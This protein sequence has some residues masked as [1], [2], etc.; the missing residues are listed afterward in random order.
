[1]RRA[2]GLILLISAA[3]WANQAAAQSLDELFRQNTQPPGLFLSDPV[4]QPD[5]PPTAEDNAYENRVLG[6][7]R[8]AQNAQGSL[9]GRWEVRGANGA[10]IYVLQFVDPG[11]GVARIEGVWRDP[12]RSGFDSTGYIESITAEDGDMVVMFREAGQS[13]ATQVRFRSVGDS[14]WSGQ[15][16]KPNGATVAVTMVRGP[17]VENRALGGG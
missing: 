14:R 13:A 11:V 10:V 1:M 3:A 8:T 16:R 9:D 7:F 5:G 2:I 17:S 4:L 6:A 15:A 12:E